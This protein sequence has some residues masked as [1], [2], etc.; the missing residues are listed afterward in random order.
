MPVRDVIALLATA[1]VVFSTG[2]GRSTDRTATATPDSVPRWE[3]FVSTADSVRLFTRVVGSGSDTI[4]VLKGGPGLTL[5]YLGPD[6]EPSDPRLWQD[7]ALPL[8]RVRS[9]AARNA[10]AAR[11]EVR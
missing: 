1:S 6:L 4:I 11:P 8:A 3:G 7:A 5:D 10:S 9:C 2:C